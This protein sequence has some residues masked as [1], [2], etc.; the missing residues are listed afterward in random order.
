M[1]ATKSNT[2]LL[3]YGFTVRFHRHCG[4]GW[5]T[6]ISDNDAITPLGETFNKPH[7]DEIGTRNDEVGIHKRAGESQK[8][9][10]LFSQDVYNS[11]TI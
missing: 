5:R 9:T 2:R 10:T 3:D 7:N 11:Q 1:P 8:Q 6:N 4:S